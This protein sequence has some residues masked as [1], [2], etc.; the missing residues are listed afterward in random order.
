MEEEK[1]PIRIVVPDLLFPDA[2][3]FL[4]AHGCRIEPRADATIM[5]I[6]TT[7]TLPPESIRQQ[8]DKIATVHYRITLPDGTVIREKYDPGSGYSSLYIP[9]YSHAQEARQWVLN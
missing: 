1:P 3:A 2:A 5:S 9:T 6:H 7:V 8:T 4:C